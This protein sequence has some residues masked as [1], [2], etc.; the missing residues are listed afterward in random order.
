MSHIVKIRNEEVV[1]NPQQMLNRMLV[2]F[3][4]TTELIEFMKYELLPR[5]P[6]LFDN[7]GYMRKPDKSALSKAL[8]TLTPYLGKDAIPP[9]AIQTVDGGNLLHTVMWTLPSTYEAVYNQYIAYVQS[10]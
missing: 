2:I 10:D 7:K 8:C 9:E 5:P 3:D 6:A 4:S 1:V